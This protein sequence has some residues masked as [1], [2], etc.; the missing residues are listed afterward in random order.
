MPQYSA[1]DGYMEIDRR[2]GHVATGGGFDASSNDFSTDYDPIT[3]LPRKV[4]KAAPPRDP[5]V[6]PN[7]VSAFKSFDADSD[8]FLNH[9]EL[10]AA[11]AAMG[12]DV[13]DADSAAMLRAYDD[14]PDGKMDMTEF[15]KLIGDLQAGTVR[16][17]C[18]PDEADV[19]VIVPEGLPPQTPFQVATPGG[20]VLSILPPD[21]AKP[22]DELRVRV[23]TNLKPAQEGGDETMLVFVPDGV[24]PGGAFDI[25]TRHGDKIQISVPALA[26]PGQQVLLKVPPPKP[27]SNPYSD[28]AGGRNALKVLATQAVDEN[29][30]LQDEMSFL[31]HEYDADG[32]GTITP[33]ELRRLL[34]AAKPDAPDNVIERAAARAM[35]KGDANKDGCLDFDEY[36][37]VYNL[38]VDLIGHNAGPAAVPPGGP[39]PARSGMSARDLMARGQSHPHDA[40]TSQC[41]QCSACTLLERDC[42]V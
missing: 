23:P 20:G 14:S 30:R 39:P 27:S 3:G 11:L 19:I 31:F 37:Q 32:D 41:I 13:S 8:G 28:P 38:L 17:L 40:Q 7:L 33:A 35:Q 26:S 6:D 25:T 4:F 36:V 15:I 42:T 12:L 10:R 2:N 16:P 1:S 5:G 9:S 29:A 21:G 22:G 34:R 18:G 24:P